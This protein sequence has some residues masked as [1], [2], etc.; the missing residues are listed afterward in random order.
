MHT[1]SWSDAQAYCAWAGARLPTEAEWEYAARGG[2]LGWGSPLRRY[3]PGERVTGLRL[4]GL[5]IGLGGAFVQQFRFA[6]ADN[7]PPEFKA[8]AISFVPTPATNAGAG[9]PA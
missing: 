4:L 6:A 1:V 9:A 8:R 5:V 7:A 2:R 3:A